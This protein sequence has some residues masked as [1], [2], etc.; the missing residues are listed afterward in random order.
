MNDVENIINIAL[1]EV[2]Y[3]EKR[4]LKNLDSKD[5]NIGNNN[6]T[7]YARDLDNISG[8]YNGKKQG[9]PWCDVFVDWCFVKAFGASEAKRKLYQPN[10]SLG[11]GTT[12]SKKYYVSNNAYYDN[13]N[14]GDQIFFKN[15]KGNVFH[16]GLVYKIDN[17]YVYTIEG[18]TSS[19]F[20]IDANGGCVVKKK[21]KLNNTVIDGYGR[22]KYLNVPNTNQV[23]IKYVYNCTSLNVRNKPNIKGSIVKTLPVSTQ[24][25]VYEIKNNW[26]RIGENEWVSN[27]YLSNTIQSKVLTKKVFNCKVLNIRNK[28]SLLGKVVGAVKCGTTV[29]VYST[30]NGWSKI[31]NNNEHY[32]YSKYLK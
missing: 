17:N 22:P 14:I 18:N 29:K 10:N 1:N 21:Y 26:A 15:K 32:V 13:P 6:Y 9:Y 27:N 19:V 4:D 2:G 3:I 31:S 23:N 12:Y 25:I 7:K 20:E 11:A 8:F 30:K 5:E 16:T 28:P 24:V